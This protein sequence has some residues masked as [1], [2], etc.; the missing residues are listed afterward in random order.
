VTRSIETS[1]RLSM[2]KNPNFPNDSIKT[3]KVAFLIADGF[4]NSAVAEMKQAL[5]TAGA[6]AMTVAPR[7]GMLMGI[8]GEQI[9]ADFSFLTASS[10][11]FDAVYVPGGEESVAALRDVPEAADFLS[12]A[13]KHCKTIAANSAGVELL[14]TSLAGKFRESDEAGDGVAI[15]EGIVTA[16]EGTV[17]DVAAGF[18]EAI[19]RHRHWEREPAV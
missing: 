2:L 9:K 15:T 10:V 17:K 16:R 7:L 3:R 6:A 18:I 4:D 12:E 5:L 8:N 1:P 19:A 14:A 11:L 13:Y